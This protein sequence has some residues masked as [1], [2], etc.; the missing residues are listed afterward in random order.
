ME[1]S[2][3]KNLIRHQNHEVIKFVTKEM[4]TNELYDTIKNKTMS[5]NKRE[6]LEIENI[7]PNIIY[8]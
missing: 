5:K 3:K 4:K 2:I 1:Q 7:V 6:L 8:M